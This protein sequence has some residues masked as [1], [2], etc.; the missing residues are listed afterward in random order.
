MLYFFTLTDSMADKMATFFHTQKNPTT[1]I[2]KCDG[3]HMKWLSKTLFGFAPS[4]SASAIG[5]VKKSHLRKSTF[6]LLIIL[7]TV[8]RHF[9][10]VLRLGQNYFLNFNC[11]SDLH[12]MLLFC[13]Y[14]VTY[15]KHCYLA[16]LFFFDLWFCLVFTQGKPIT[17]IT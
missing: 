15:K 5:P 10:N 13:R 14:F 4:C 9:E 2:S 17:I 8:W 12:L 1:P 6:L 3:R 11:C 7:T 16:F